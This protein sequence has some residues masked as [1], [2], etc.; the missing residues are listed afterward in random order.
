MVQN[1]MTSVVGKHINCEFEFFFVRILSTSDHI[2]KANVNERKLWYI[3]GCHH[4]FILISSSPRSI[5][6]I[7]YIRLL[8]A[9]ARGFEVVM[10]ESS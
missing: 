3:L 10:N 1:T 6:G 5:I 7:P 9:F 4:M 8:A 2:V